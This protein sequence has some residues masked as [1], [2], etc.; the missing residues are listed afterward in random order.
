[1]VVV[2]P[3]RSPGSSRR[4]PLHRRAAAGRAARRLARVRARVRVRVLL[5][6]G[7]GFC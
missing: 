3:A 5:V 7:L 4:R 2:R 1:M 6:L